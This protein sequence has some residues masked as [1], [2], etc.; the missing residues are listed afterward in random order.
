MGAIMMAH[1]Y[2]ETRHSICH[3]GIHHRLA[4]SKS[5]SN[6]YQNIPR[7]IFGILAGRKYLCPGHNDSSNGNEEKH[8]QLDFRKSF[9]D[10][11]KF[12]NRCTH[13]HQY[14]QSQG[15]PA[16]SLSGHRFRILAIGQ[17]HEHRRFPPGLY[18]RVISHHH[19]RIPFA[20]IFIFQISNNALT[21]TLNLLHFGPIMPL[22]VKITKFLVDTGKTGAE[23]SFHPM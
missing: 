6:R 4:D 18:K 23:Y 19:Q 9:L 16:L 11:R 21:A 17:Q 15:K 12:T 2:N 22:E 5:T 1:A 13:Y 8:I 3:S 20:E 14:Q 10:N 7:Y